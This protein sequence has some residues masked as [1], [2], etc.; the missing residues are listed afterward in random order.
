MSEFKNF[1]DVIKDTQ[2]KINITLQKEI[3]EDIKALMKQHIKND[4][5]DA[6]TSSAKVPYVRRKE[7]GGLLDNNNFQITFVKGQLIVKN[8]TKGKDNNEW[9]IPIIETGKGYTWEESEI[10]KTKLSR[11]FNELTQDDLEKGEFLK[12]L[13]KQLFMKYGIVIKMSK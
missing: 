11:P 2:M 10:Y 4:V 3:A 13:R 12:I 8:I 7:N 1:D 9:I 6:Y 5:Y